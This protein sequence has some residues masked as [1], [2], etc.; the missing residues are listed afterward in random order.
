MATWKDKCLTLNIYL[1]SWFTL[2]FID[3]HNIIWYRISL[4]QLSQLCSLPTSGVPPRLI[5]E[6]QHPEHCFAVSKTLVCYQHCSSHKSK[7]KCCKSCYKGNKLNARQNRKPNFWKNWTSDFEWILPFIK[8]VL[9]PSNHNE[10]NSNHPK[11]HSEY[12]FSYL[13]LI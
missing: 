2:F 7:P 12:C 5:A 10:W 3:G 4:G 13:Y 6:P 1:S 9:Q 11:Y 8:K